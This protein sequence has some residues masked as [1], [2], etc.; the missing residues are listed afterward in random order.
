MN[1]LYA[2]CMTSPAGYIM[3]VVILLAFFVFVFVCAKRGFINIFFSFVSS[4]VAL[5]AAIALAK[6]FVNVTGGLFGIEN[7]MAEKFTATF[8]KMKGFNVDVSGEDIGSL[9][10]AGALPALIGK[11][12]VKKYAGETFASDTTL[13][14]LAGETVAGLFCSLIAGIFLFILIKILIRILRKVFTKISKKIDLIGKLNRILGMLIGFIEGILIISIFVSI[15]ALIPSESINQFF[16][17]S[18]ILR[19]LYNRNPIVWM[20]GWF[21]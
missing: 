9:L 11:L 7:S 19:F 17:N 12:M 20:L 4:V 5:F 15:L 18:L 21:I 1:A 13:G 10:S 3:D 8:S 2:L 6:V 16:N 14:M